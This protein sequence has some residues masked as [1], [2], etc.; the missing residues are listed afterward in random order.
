MEHKNKPKS[1]KLPGT[2]SPHTGQGLR[3]TATSDPRLPLWD[4]CTNLSAQEEHSYDTRGS[5]RDQHNLPR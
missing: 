1:P 2:S 4:F 5:T 3:V